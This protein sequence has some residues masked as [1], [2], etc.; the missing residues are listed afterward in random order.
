MIRVKNNFGV[1]S[2]HAILELN[3]RK[4]VIECSC[5]EKEILNPKCLNPHHILGFSLCSRGK[6]SFFFPLFCIFQLLCQLIL[7]QKGNLISSSYLT[8]RSKTVSK[9][10]LSKILNFKAFKISSLSYSLTSP[11]HSDINF[12]LQNKMWIV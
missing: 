1:R 8:K 6:F 9:P 3:F 11:L 4:L 7:L 12:T 2:Q 10:P 5:Q